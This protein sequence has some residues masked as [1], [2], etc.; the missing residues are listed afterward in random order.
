MGNRG[1]WMRLAGAVTGGL[2]VAGVFA[3]FNLTPLVWVAMLPFFAA[4]AG[5]EGKRVAWKGFWLGLV[6]GFVSFGIELDWLAV[7][8]TAGAVVLPLYLAVYW[9][10][11]GAFAA[12]LGRLEGR[13]FGKILGLAFA[14]G[15]MW[16]GLEI[17][18]GWVFTGFGWNGL[19]V[20]FHNQLVM[21]QGADLLGV[22]G[23]SGFLVF[24]QA[25]AFAAWKRR[26]WKPLA[27]GLAATALLAGYGFFRISS[28]K[29]RESVRLKSLLVQLNIPQEAARMEW[30]AEE[31]H[32]AY[33]DE[34]LKGLAANKAQWPD[35]VI[36]PETA[37]TG[38]ILRMADGSWAMWEQNSETIAQVR[39]AGPFSLI[40]GAVELEGIEENGALLPKPRG[41]VYNSL[42]AM[43]PRDDLQTFRK[44]HLVI[45]GETIPF[46]DSIPL[47]KKIY[48]EQSGA[49]F[50]GSFTEGT[51]F[52]P[53]HLGAAGKR[54]GLIPT[55][56]FEDTVPRLNRKFV[57]PGPQVIMNVTNDG[58]FKTT[59]AAEQHFQNA[60]FRAIELRRPMIRCANSG[61]SAAIDSTGSTKNPDTGVDQIIR[62]GKGSHF[63]RGSLLVQ[64]QVP[65]DPLFSLYAR[66]GDAGALAL[67][68]AGF[69][70]AVG[71]RKNRKGWDEKDT[72]F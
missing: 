53:L 30:T 13:S 59:Q 68:G 29:S 9:G 47:L 33:E 64:L 25:L 37:L 52:E 45:F 54:I 65:V 38:R 26:D 4:V 71:L 55:V 7:V 58:W 31:T 67:A 61:V 6:A 51:S 27:A 69:F 42:V 49:E 28:E 35:W 40:Y 60:R 72:I 14:N 70:L 32:M 2:L 23:L 12:T 21:A 50:N 56:C 10:L 11:F 57:R 46:V 15:A 44:H 19:G 18:R 16:A 20:G 41:E 24:V 8:T 22:A 48:E 43:D 36:W 5:L 34:T 3:P 39:T 66:I 1:F 63:M 62:D 17:A